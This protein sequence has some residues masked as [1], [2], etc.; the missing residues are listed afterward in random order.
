MVKLMF[1]E[2]QEAATFFKGIVRE[3]ITEM[4]AEGHFASS[5]QSA[6]LEHDAS[7]PWAKTKEA[8][9]ILKYKSPTSMQGVR[10]DSPDN[11]IIISKRGREYLYDR[12]SLR[13]YMERKTKRECR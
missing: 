7:D 2:D 9:K 1:L 11:G 4:V 6:P 10:K 5:E 8:M 12:Q 3:V 13:D